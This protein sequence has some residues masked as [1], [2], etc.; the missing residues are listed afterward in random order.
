MDDNLEEHDDHTKEYKTKCTGLGALLGNIRA[1][2]PSPTSSQS[3]SKSSEVSASSGK[4]EENPKEAVQD[5]ASNLPSK[6][7]PPKESIQEPGIPEKPSN[8]PNGVY[9]KLCD[10][11]VNDHRLMTVHVAGRNHRAR[12]GQGGNISVCNKRKQNTT[13]QFGDSYED[14]LFLLN[15]DPNEPVLGEILQNLHF[16]ICDK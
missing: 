2:P 11:Y 10:I 7:N 8:M 16:L 4:S 1:D 9:C 5:E 13:N 15:L 6:S 14:L 3:A 12:A